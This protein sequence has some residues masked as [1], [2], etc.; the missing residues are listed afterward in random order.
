[1]GQAG[2]DEHKYNGVHLAHE[3]LY[4]TTVFI[5]VTFE[6]ELLLLIYLLGPVKFVHQ[7][8]YILDFI[9]VTISLVLEL[10]LHNIGYESAAEVLPSLLIL[11]RMW[12]FVR[13]GHG[14][15]ASAHEMGREK[16]LLAL[17][18]INKLEDILE[19]NGFEVPVKPNKLIHEEEQRIEQGSNSKKVKTNWSYFDASKR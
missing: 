13:I 18:H 2:C 8:M 7:F 19:T 17:D 1:M 14:L 15:V 3:A 11:I 16:I 12:R 5:L 10:L 4:W 6:V 9:V